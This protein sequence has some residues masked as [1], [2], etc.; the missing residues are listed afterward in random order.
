[1][2]LRHLQIKPRLRR[3]GGTTLAVSGELG[4]TASIELYVHDD[5]DEVRLKV[6]PLLAGNAV[7]AQSAAHAQDE[8]DPD[9]SPSD[10][11]VV[12]VARDVDGNDYLRGM[13]RSLVPPPLDDWI[14]QDRT[15]GCGNLG[16]VAL[17]ERQAHVWQTLMRHRNV[18]LYGPPGTGKTHL[19][20]GIKGAFEDGVAQLALDTAAVEEPFVAAPAESSLPDKRL[21][22]FTTF[23]QSLSYESF[24]VG[25]RPDPAQHGSGLAFKAQNGLFLELA[26]HALERDSASLL[27]VDE[28]NR[29]N[30]ADIF[31][32]LITLLEPDK[33]LGPSGCVT[34]STIAVSLPTQ[35]EAPIEQQF[36]MPSE[37][38]LLASMNSLDRSVAPLDSAL[39]RRFRHV[40]LRPN[41][42]VARSVLLGGAAEATQLA[43]PAAPTDLE[44]KTIAIKAL[45]RLNEQ[46][47]RNWGPEFLLGHAYILNVTD[48]DSLIEVFD[49]SVLPQVAETYRDQ[50]TALGEILSAG[51]ADALAAGPVPDDPAEFGGGTGVLDVK[52]L[53][54]ASKTDRASVMRGLYRLAYGAE[55]AAPGP[56][57]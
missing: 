43:D 57:L 12:F 24:V 17:D 1:L 3:E 9:A 26:G 33:R 27:L 51:E 35:P 52:P 30:V 16:G 36:R 41:M 55:W 47:Q 48:A 13:R 56:S 38:Y 19:M 7:L 32:E 25:L 5:R 28:L 18:L 50:P 39:R 4:S 54:E 22:K 15:G 6:P 44:A 45:T 10:E 49:E 21:A 8:I 42:D 20:M 14:R 34:T 46:L 37:F 29:G 2:W 11:F 53:V 31:G 23:H 40:N